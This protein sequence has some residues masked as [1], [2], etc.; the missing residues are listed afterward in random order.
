MRT[1]VSVCI[2]RVPYKLT[3]VFFTNDP[4]T[5]ILYLLSQS[6]FATTTITVDLAAASYRVLVFLPIGRKK[7]SFGG[8]MP[9]SYDLQSWAIFITHNTFHIICLGMCFCATGF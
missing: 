1:L 3:A 2:S 8:D 7:R 6:F 5:I 4:K 9:I